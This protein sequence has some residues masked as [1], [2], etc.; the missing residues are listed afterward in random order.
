MSASIGIDLGAIWDKR[1][2]GRITNGPLTHAMIADVER[3][4]GGALPTSYIDL[5]RLRNGGYLAKRGHPRVNGEVRAIWG[6]G[7]VKGIGNH[8]WR[9]TLKYMDQEGIEEPRGLDKMVPFFGDGHYFVCFDFNR[10]EMG[11]PA[12]SFVDVELFEPVVTVSPSF[13]QFLAELEP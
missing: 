4:I 7:P 1:D 12:I 6:I 5:L 9:E 13:A 10:L 11:E 8:S 2:T 3:R